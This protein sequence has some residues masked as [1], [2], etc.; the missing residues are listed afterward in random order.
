MI[1]KFLHIRLEL[2]Y[3]LSPENPRWAPFDKGVHNNVV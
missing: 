1:L 2:Q 3:T